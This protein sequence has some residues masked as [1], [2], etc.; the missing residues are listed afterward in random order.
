MTSIFQLLKKRKES[1]ILW[2]LS[3]LEKKRFMESSKYSKFSGLTSHLM[4]R[5]LFS[6]KKPFFLGYLIHKS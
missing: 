6:S 4:V 5:V 3:F 2:L 1:L